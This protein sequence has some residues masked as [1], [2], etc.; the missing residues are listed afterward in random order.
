MIPGLGR[1]PGEGNGNLF[2]Y[3]R[4]ENL[5]GRGA[6]WAIVHGVAELDMTNQLT[7]TRIEGFPNGASGKEPPAKAGGMRRGFDPWVKKVPWRRA[8]QL[9]S[10]FFSI[11]RRDE[12]VRLQSIESQ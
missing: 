9:T 10:V 7:H 1:S 6:W 4:L 8:W 2:Q 5:M 3:S 11:P 12:P